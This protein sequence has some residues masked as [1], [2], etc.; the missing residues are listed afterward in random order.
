V[1]LAAVLIGATMLVAALTAHRGKPIWNTEGGAELPLLFGL[2][3]I[4]LTFQGAG[5]WSLDHAFGWGAELSG[6][7][8]GLGAIALVAIG[9]LGVVT[10]ARRESGLPAH[11]ATAR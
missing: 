3:P 9:G 11:G 10:L 6:L 7:G 4:A 2:V 5:R 8:W 1:P